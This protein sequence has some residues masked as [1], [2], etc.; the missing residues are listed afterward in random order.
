MHRSLIPRWV[1]GLRL[2]HASHA[3]PVSMLWVVFLLGLL[4]RSTCP[5]GPATGLST[6]RSDTFS[7]RSTVV[8][9]SVLYISAGLEVLI[10]AR[11][12]IDSPPRTLRL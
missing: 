2:L 5:S 9:F 10:R 7:V 6:L 8:T 11:V 1:A 12:P 4:L 3:S